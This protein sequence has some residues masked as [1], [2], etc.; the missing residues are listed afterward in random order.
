MLEDTEPTINR[1]DLTC[2]RRFYVSDVSLSSSCLRERSELL[3]NALFTKTPG[4]LSDRCWLAFRCNSRL[5]PAFDSRCLN[6]CPSRECRQIL[7]ETCPNEL[8]I[9]ADPLAF[10]HVHLLLMKSV[11]VSDVLQKQPT[12]ICYNPQLCEG[13]SPNGTLLSINNMTCRPPADFPVT[14]QAKG[15]FDWT[16][17]YVKPLYEQLRKCNTILYDEPIN[18]DMGNMYQ[19]RNSGRCISI[20]RRCDGIVDCNE[21][22]DEECTSIDRNCSTL[23]SNLFF[24]CTTT[25]Q[26]ISVKRVNDRRCDCG[27]DEFDLCDDETAEMDLIR[28]RIS[29]PTI[30]DGFQEL[31]P[32]LIDGRNESDETECQHWQ[33]N[34]TYTRCDGIWHC[35]DGADE[36]NC[37]QSMLRKCPFGHHV[38]VSSTT[39]RLI[40]L[41]ISKANDGHID[42]LGATDEP[43][44]CR[45]YSRA[46]SLSSN[47]FHCQNGT[48][49]ICTSPFTLCSSKATCPHRDDQLFCTPNTNRTASQRLCSEEQ[50]WSRSDAENFFCRLVTNDKKAQKVHFSIDG[51]TNVSPASQTHT[52][53]SSIAT[54]IDLSQQRCHRG[55]RL[56]VRSNT[57]PNNSTP[58]CLCPPSYYGSECQYEN[59]RVGLTLR[60]QTYSDSQRTLFA[61]LVYLID[62]SEQR[63]IHSYEKLTYLYV[64]HCRTKFNMQLFYSTRP[65]QPGRNYSIHIDI[66]EKINLIYRGSLFLA[67][68]YSFL[69]VNR[70]AVQL[71]I[72]QTNK[73]TELCFDLPCVHG[74]C[75]R[76][77][78]EQETRRGFCQCEQGWSGKHCQ[79]EHRCSCSVGS[80]CVGVSTNN[81]SICVCPL[82]RW[83]P[84]CLLVST[85]CDHLDHNQTCLNGGECFSM[86][87]LMTEDRKFLC[88]CRPGYSGGRCELLDPTIKVTFDT[89]MA[90][91]SSILIH[92]LRVIA[93]GPPENGSTFKNIP[94]SQKISDHSMDTS[95]SCSL[96]PTVYPSLLSHCCSEDPQPIYKHRSNRS[97]FWSMSSLKRYFQRDDRQLSSPSSS[98]ILSSRLST[99]FASS[100]VFLW[101]KSFLCMP[102]LRPSTCC[103]LFRIQCIDSTRLFRSKQLWAWCSV[104]TG[105]SRMSADLHL[106]LSWMFLWHTMSIQFK[107]IRAVPRRYSWIL[108]STEDQYARTTECG[109]RYSLTFTVVMCVAGLINGVLSL[110]TFLNVEPRK[111]GCGIYL[112]NS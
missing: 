89:E 10:G 76:Y 55:L 50:A 23:G 5:F 26:C 70:L 38:C 92:F 91:P 15:R 32:L 84:R 88:M 48:H 107:C 4:G 9:P 18:C 101:P 53:S 82:H 27:Y 68:K 103:Q 98:E 1:E 19:C 34:N 80:V 75:I 72:P 8:L 108:H 81:T 64:E 45:Q 69:P 7:N 54:I 44:L 77:S 3:Q 12:Y 39:Y 31:K 94:T 100:I 90:L 6:E 110:L 78:N 106:C 65:K 83:G 20:Q 35:L 66:Y 63:V 67:V 105:Q 51:T 47:N 102:R 28:K 93:N 57:N 49:R 16:E 86:D 97:S 37:D 21:R 95:I 29:F 42:C 11:V 104:F 62:N 111:V 74:R 36:V 14:F 41:P 59:E 33:C 46:G 24:Q 30:C 73:I 40:C 96:S 87:D 58:T 43:L 99:V 71:N 112:F 17:L 85:T 109:D 79:M 25:N 22:D 13:L 61:L 60:M 52:P 56:R 2:N